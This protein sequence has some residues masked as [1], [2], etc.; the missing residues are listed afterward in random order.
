[1]PPAIAQTLQ[2]L[3][4]QRLEIEPP[5][6]APQRLEFGPGRLLQAS[7]DH[8]VLRETEHGESMT[9]ANLGLVL[10]IAHG[11]DGALFAL[12]TSA[13]VRFESHAKKGRAF[14]AAAFFPNS[15][16]FPDLE[17]PTEFYVYYPTQQ[18]LLRYLF[19]AEAG[20]VLAIDA[21]IP[22]EGCTSAPTQLRDGALACHTATGF[23]RKA[24]RGAR[25]DFKPAVALG[26]SFRL[27]PARR[28]DE[29]FAIE[30]AGEVKHLRLAAGVPVL[31]AFQLPA[32]P[33]AAAANGEALA[34]VLVTAPEP[35]KERRWSLLVT[36]FDGQ[37]RLRVEL[38]AKAAPADEDWAQ[39]ITEDKNLTISEYEPL[40]A[41]GGAAH[42]AVW[43]YREGKSRFAR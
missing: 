18:Q 29:L 17:Q 8:V 38:E 11:S 33:Y 24:P 10:A 19:E 34:F 20:P 22:L 6:A 37:S 32:P 2:V 40:V 43:D 7:A 3:H 30:R 27:L 42:V 39:A 5:S 36:D 14:P 13:G 9:E 4:E 16:A 26:E 41:V 25:T 31:G 15:I 35:G 21:T 28:L 1:M 12:G 23:A